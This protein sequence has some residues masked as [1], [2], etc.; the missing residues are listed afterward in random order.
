MTLVASGRRTI[1]TL[2]KS[3]RLAVGRPKAQALGVHGV[4]VPGS[5]GVSGR[6]IVDAD[7]VFA[8]SAPSMGCALAWLVVAALRSR[9]E[10]A[11]GV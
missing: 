3:S 9:G 4:W 2:D 1:P 5:P 7:R 10:A 8:R 11:A 6:R